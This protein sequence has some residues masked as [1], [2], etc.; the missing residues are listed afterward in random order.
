MKTIKTA[1]IG[2]GFMGAAH[3]EALRRTGGVEIAAIASD[4]QPRARQLAEQFGIAR[5][6]DNWR[7]VMEDKQIEAV[8]N[9]TPNHL[10]FEINK[11]AIAAGKHII[12]EKPLTLTTAESAE[13]LRL[14]EKTPVANAVNFNYRMYPLIQQA[15][16][17][18]CKGEVGQIYLV[19]G[20]YL[21]DWLFYETDYNWRLEKELSGQSRAV[22]DIG[23]HWCDLIQFITGLKIKRVC[24]DL[25]TIHKTRQRPRHAVETF[26]GKEESVAAEVDA[27]EISTEDTASVLF[28]FENGSRGAFTVSQVSAGRKNQFWFEI[29]GSKKALAW[30]QEEPNRLWVGYREKGN[31]IIMKDPSLLDEGARAYAHYPGG[32]PE[33]YPDGPKNLFRNFYE[34]IRQGKNP[35]NDSADFPTFA[36]GHWE[37]QVVEAILKS[38]REEK[39]VEV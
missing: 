18:V 5:V 11:A 32:H 7:R 28:Q 13:L 31:E 24:A 1:V 10:H 35:L 38:S 17:S 16:N 36:D 20:H 21:Q 33:G 19:H 22:A 26:K 14:L 6:W 9:C 37:N 15:R 29:D 39:W 4:D 3:I 25:N 30:N 23:S 27:V 2:S 34:F 8:H 12:S